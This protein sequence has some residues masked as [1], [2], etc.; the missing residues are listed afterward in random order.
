MT[1]SIS[2][3]LLLHLKLCLLHKLLT[4]TLRCSVYIEMI[5]VRQLIIRSRR[6]GFDNKVDDALGS[7]PQGI[8]QCIGLLI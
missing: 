8:G 2:S 3:L 4:R 1:D 5:L 7:P 6:R